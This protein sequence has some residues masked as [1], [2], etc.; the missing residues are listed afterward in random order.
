MQNRLNNTLF[1]SINIAMA[2]VYMI[3][4]QCQGAF[5]GDKPFSF[6]CMYIMNH[7]NKC[8]MFNASKKFLNQTEWN[9]SLICSLNFSCYA[10][11]Q[12]KWY[13]YLTKLDTHLQI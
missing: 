2:T 1:G 12:H 6:K 5:L 8:C 9:I 3:Y 10:F 4:Y 13:S 11:Y 7:M